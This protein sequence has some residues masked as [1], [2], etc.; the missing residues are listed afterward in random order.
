YYIQQ[1]LLNERL[2]YQKE[3][4][5]TYEGRFRFQCDHLPITCFEW[6][7]DAVP[8][9]S[10]AKHVS[11]ESITQVL[12]SVGNATTSLTGWLS[13]VDRGD[14]E[15]FRGVDANQKVLVTL[16]KNH[17]LYR[18]VVDDEYP[19]EAHNVISSAL[20]SFATPF[21]LVWFFGGLWVVFMHQARVYRIKYG[22]QFRAME[23]HQ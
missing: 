19:T 21:A 4:T 22:K 14:V 10:I 20:L 15:V 5:A 11:T 6:V 8:V 17:E 9:T 12:Q 7:G 1:H 18:V 3:L 16:Y 2:T 23:N 13:V